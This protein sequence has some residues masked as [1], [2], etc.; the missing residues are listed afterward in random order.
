MCYFAMTGVAVAALAYAALL[1]LRKPSAQTTTP[2]FGFGASGVAVTLS[3][4]SILFNAPKI[5]A[6]FLFRDALPANNGLEIACETQSE[7]LGGIPIFQFLLTIPIMLF[8]L[9]NQARLCARWTFARLLKQELVASG[10]TAGDTVRVV[11]VPAYR[12]VWIPPLVRAF[13]QLLPA[14]ANPAT[15]SVEVMA[16]D[17]FGTA[18]QRESDAWLRKNM[19]LE[20]VADDVTVL[21]TD[22]LTLPIPSGSVDVLVVPVSRGLPFLNDSRSS[23]QRK[24]ELKLLFLAECARVLKPGGRIA[25]SAL[26]GFEVPSWKK[27]LEEAGFVA[28]TV[29]RPWIWFAWIPS[30]LVLATKSAA[31]VAPAAAK[32]DSVATTTVRLGAAGAGAAGAA[33]T[34]STRASA[35]LRQQLHRPPLPARGWFPGGGL[36]RLRDALVLATLALYVGCCAATAATFDALLVPNF[37][38]WGYTVG[39]AILSVLLTTPIA[40]YY[41]SSDLSSF[42]GELE[43]AARAGDGVA[44]G[45]HEHT[46]STS[47]VS[48]ARGGKMQA[49]LLAGAAAD[50]LT[51]TR[52]MSVRRS[53][54]GGAAA[55]P[56]DSATLRA[57]LRRYGTELRNCVFGLVVYQIFTWAP[58]FLCNTILLKAGASTDTANIATIIFTVILFS[59]VIPVGK[60]VNACLVARRNKQ[61]QAAEAAEAA[62]S[63]TLD[64]EA[65]G[66]GVSGTA[67]VVPANGAVVG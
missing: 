11:A 16:C 19:E 52:A 33:S 28:P 7:S 9:F 5:V 36:W 45:A 17:A 18:L 57:V 62:S 41:L 59:L 23:D 14:S 21:Q 34:S 43:E 40:L 60:R 26:V 35:A 4:T 44:R 12:G 1:T 38:G 29:V 51:A 65:Q 27:A 50:P 20:G 32:T 10:F 31:A 64:L 2:S 48:R 42:C 67:V 24:Q 39:N 6:F 63:A 56:L 58:G 3:I 8:V 53:V 55:P 25:G 13:R 30:Q 61:L 66:V 37:V 22:F 47:R 54:R 49:P 15:A 46:S